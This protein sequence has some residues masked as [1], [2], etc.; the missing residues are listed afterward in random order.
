MTPL[1]LGSWEK[2]VGADGKDIVNGLCAGCA[3]LVNAGEEF[4]VLHHPTVRGGIFHARCSPSRQDGRWYGV[5]GDD[6]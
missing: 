1:D 6:E 2:R 3:D 5:G 4:V